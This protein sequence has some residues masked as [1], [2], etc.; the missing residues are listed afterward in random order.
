M[1]LKTTTTVTGKVVTYDTETGRIVSEGSNSSSSDNSSSNNSNSNNSNNNSNSSSS[2][3]SS[4]SSNMDNI[5]NA[6]PNA[7]ANYGIINAIYQ[8]KYGRDAT[9]A[10]LDRFVNMPVS[11]VANI[12]LGP[13]DSPFSGYNPN[14]N[15][16]NNNNNSNND[17]SNNNTTEADEA[18][19]IEDEI[20]AQEEADAATLQESYDMIDNAVAN[21]LIDATTG[22]LYKGV[23]ANYSGTDVN[24]EDIIAE[25]NRISETTISPEYDQRIDEA[26]AE[27]TNAKTYL[28]DKR[29]I[30][31]ESETA[32]AE[33]QLESAKSSLESSGL[34]FSGTAGEYLGKKSALDPNK[35]SG[36][37]GEGTLG[38]Y[39][40]QI[41][42]SSQ[43]D[44]LNSIQDLTT[45]SEGLLGSE[46][47]GDLGL[48]EGLVGGNAGSI[49]DDRQV[50]LADTL[51]QIFLNS[52]TANNLDATHLT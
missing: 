15:S 8:E 11:D 5:A 43:A 44:Y 33:G 23:V 13:A 31:L 29:A 19:R 14:E 30:A 22:E 41:S 42:S 28:E 6:D 18:K 45:E 37:L 24:F 4:S 47:T 48:S 34:S 32:T 3:S 2:N 39:Q 27:I 1:P 20:K 10:E 9:Q 40:R 50:D 7:S 51:D 12:I 17:N 21:G 38:A 52:T 36:E 25:L 49:E 35:V 16:N 26:I 46:Q